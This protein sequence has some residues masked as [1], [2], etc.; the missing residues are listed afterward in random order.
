[1]DLRMPDFL[2]IGAMKAG[3]T[4]LFK[5]LNAHSRCSLPAKEPNFFCD[6]AWRQRMRHYSDLFAGIP[7]ALST[8]EASHLYTAPR[9]AQRAARRIHETLPDAKLVFVAREPVSRLRSSYRHEVQRG[10][11]KLRLPEAVASGKYVG[12]SEYFRC[13]SP[14]LERFSRRQILVVTSEELFAPPYSGWRQV[15]AH[16]EVPYEEPLGIA[17]NVTEKKAQFRP[18]THWLWR[19]G[20]LP[21]G[22]FPEPVRRLGK[23]ILLKKD[24]SYEE[25]MRSS[26]EPLPTSLIERLEEDS[27]KLELWLG[28][29]LWTN[30]EAPATKSVLT[31]LVLRDPHPSA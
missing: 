22:R 25:L 24:A 27:R 28:R 23:R 11:E 7:A 3:T 17:F 16:L 19:R 13:L 20:W 14:H 29:T 10:R 1:M 15:L 30:V 5:W 18:A 4:S 6:D 21:T 2:I 26:R 9:F 31:R 8:G 12:K